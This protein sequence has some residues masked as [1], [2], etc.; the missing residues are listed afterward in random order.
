MCVCMFVCAIRS[1]QYTVYFVLRTPVYTH[2]AVYEDLHPFSMNHS[3]LSH[4]LT[5]S[6]FTS[7]NWHLHHRTSHSPLQTPTPK[8]PPKM[9]I[10]LAPLSPPSLPLF[11]SPYLVA[12]AHRRRAHHSIIRSLFVSPFLRHPRAATPLAAAR[13]N[14]V[15]SGLGRDGD[16]RISG[17]GQGCCDNELPPMTSSAS[18][19]ERRPED[20]DVVHVRIII[21]GG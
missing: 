13:L 12:A 9:P 1:T 14:Q 2:N 15:T 8:Q 7:S 11:P 19:V 10:L 17:D 18:H 6:I 5:A 16:R 20:P 4:S 3:F 21:M